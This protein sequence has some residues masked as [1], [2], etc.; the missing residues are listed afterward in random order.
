MRMRQFTDARP[1]RSPE[2]CHASG[3]AKSAPDFK[4]TFDGHHVSRGLGASAISA[5]SWTDASGHDAGACSQ[6]SIARAIAVWNVTK[7]ETGLPGMTNAT[8]RP[9]V[10][11]MSGLPGRR[12]IWRK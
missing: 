5:P 12:L 10:A 3:V 9:R 8:C 1:Q 11:K 6:H 2:L 7:W 4:A